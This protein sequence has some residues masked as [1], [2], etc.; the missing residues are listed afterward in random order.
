MLRHM[1]FGLQVGFAEQ[2][3]LACSTQDLV[4]NVES[5]LKEDLPYTIAKGEA[6]EKSS[7]DEMEDYNSIF[8]L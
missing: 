2:E 3:Q 6:I 4:V 5:S 7:M 1:Q 8:K